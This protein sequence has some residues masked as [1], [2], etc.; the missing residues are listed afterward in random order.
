LP[1]IVFRRK[2]IQNLIDDYD[3]N[4]EWLGYRELPYTTM[5]KV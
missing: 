4:H 3:R 2:I 1:T 5:P